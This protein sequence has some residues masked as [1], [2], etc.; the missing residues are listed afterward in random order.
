MPAK[1]IS[2]CAD[3]ANLERYGKVVIDPMRNMPIAAGIVLISAPS[4][5]G[6]GHTD[7]VTRIRPVGSIPKVRK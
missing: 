2:C 7:A 1:L 6:I 5:T 3:K 4:R